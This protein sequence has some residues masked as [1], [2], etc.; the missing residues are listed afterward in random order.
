MWKWM[1]LQYIRTNNQVYTHES[2]GTVISFDETIERALDVYRLSFCLRRS[3]K[4][5]TVVNSSSYSC[6]Q[7]ALINKLVRKL[8]TFQAF[9]VRC[10][11]CLFRRN[12]FQWLT[13][14]HTKFLSL[15][16]WSD[17]RSMTLK[18]ITWFVICFVAIILKCNLVWKSNI[19]W[20]FI[21]I[22]TF[23]L[24]LEVF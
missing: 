6:Q 14:G 3:V 2:E 20:F 19:W 24:F 21:R 23:L 17:F 12:V 16:E 10:G 22:C 13:K 9:R 18:K 7:N 1:V 15:S 11:V 5:I 4:S 8:L